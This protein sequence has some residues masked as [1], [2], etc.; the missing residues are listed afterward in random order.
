MCPRCGSS[1]LLVKQLEGFERLL[2]QLTRKR[3]YRCRLCEC[4][5]RMPDRRASRRD[6][7]PAGDARRIS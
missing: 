1:V 2:A 5:F 3:A 4:R 6:R 7:E